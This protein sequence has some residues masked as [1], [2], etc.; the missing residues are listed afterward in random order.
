MNSATR[1]HVWDDRKQLV[2]TAREVLTISAHITTFVNKWNG[3][4]QDWHIETMCYSNLN[5]FRYFSLTAMFHSL[6]PKG[7]IK[8]SMSFRG[9]RFRRTSPKVQFLLN[10][11]TWPIYTILSFKLVWIASTEIEKFLI[12]LIFLIL[13]QPVALGMQL[14]WPRP[15]TSKYD[16]LKL[17]RLLSGAYMSLIRST[18]GIHS[19][20]C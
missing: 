13:F 15:A 4:E 8:L 12:Y 7:P 10:H 11:C 3:Q 5:M 14:T 17:F 18:G 20:W 9:N 2:E 19:Q 6:N 16:N 1:Q